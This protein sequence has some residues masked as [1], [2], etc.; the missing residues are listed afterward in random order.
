MTKSYLGKIG[1][2]VYSRGAAR[3]PKPSAGAA[4]SAL[5]PTNRLGLGPP[6]GQ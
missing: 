4:D 3:N 6:T 5:A 1:R 2:S